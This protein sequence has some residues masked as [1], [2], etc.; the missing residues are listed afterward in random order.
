VHLESTIDQWYYAVICHACGRRIPFSSIEADIPTCA[1]EL[2]CL[3]C[4]KACDYSPTEFV[5][6]AASE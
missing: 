2:S 1:M 3:E 4:F 5:R 6:V